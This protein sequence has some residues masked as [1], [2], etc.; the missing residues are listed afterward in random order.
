MLTKNY[1]VIFGEKLVFFSVI[2]TRKHAQVAA[3]D[4]GG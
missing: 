4:F 1:K 3:V 2:I